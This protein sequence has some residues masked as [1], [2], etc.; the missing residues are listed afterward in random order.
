MVALTDAE[1]HAAADAAVNDY[2][3]GAP[4][5]IKVE[6]WLADRW[7]EDA[8]LAVYLAELHDHGRAPASA[9]TAVAGACF[10]ARL[11]R[12]P[13]PAGERT[14]RVLAGYRRTGGRGRG[15]GQARAFGAADLAGG[16]AD[17]GSSPTRS[18][19]RR[20][21]IARPAVSR[22]WRTPV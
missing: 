7:L 9:S 10:R 8:T 21:R 12:E 1:I 11:A 6:V 16:G 22:R 5:D 2:A 3:P 20:K 17:A 13:S 19:T 18:A 15:R 14:P 4:G